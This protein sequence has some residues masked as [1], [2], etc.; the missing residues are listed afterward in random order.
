[1]DVV[2]LDSN[3]LFSIGICPPFYRPKKKYQKS[4]NIVGKFLK[5]QVECGFT[6]VS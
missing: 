2:A 1:M 5:L 4:S 3:P 6:L